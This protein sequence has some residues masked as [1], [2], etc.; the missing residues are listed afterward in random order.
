MREDIYS[1]ASQ[2]EYHRALY[3]IME[4]IF[5]CG[6]VDLEPKDDYDTRQVLSWY[7]INCGSR[8]TLLVEM[9]NIGKIKGFYVFEMD[10][11]DNE[12][13]VVTDSGGFA[14]DF[15]RH[16]VDKQSGHVLFFE[17]EEILKNVEEFKIKSGGNLPQVTAQSLVGGWSG[18]KNN[19][20]DFDK[21]SQVFYFNRKKVNKNGKLSIQELVAREHLRATGITSRQGQNM[22]WERV[23]IETSKSL[24]KKIEKEVQMQIFQ[25]TGE[26]KSF[27]GIYLTFVGKCEGQMNII[28]YREKMLITENK[29][30]KLNVKQIAEDMQEI[31]QCLSLMDLEV[32]NLSGF[33]TKCGDTLGLDIRDCLKIYF[34]ELEDII[35]ESPD[36]S[37]SFL[38]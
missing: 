27:P 8:I 33:Q 4:K 38:F 36:V 10:M 22:M 34:T 12:Q 19:P 37:F 6:K 16:T 29:V 28:Q 20:I 25:R 24:P 35:N 23:L 14:M 1:A 31:K 15:S 11:D 32:D 7:S 13:V 18:E 30:T 26:K 21:R 2:I 3:P 9:Y 5:G 17:E